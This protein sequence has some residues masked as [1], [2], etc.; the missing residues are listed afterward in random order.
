MIFI[1][2]V[3][4][5][6]SI[7]VLLTLTTR[8]AYLLR[9]FSMIRIPTLF[10]KILEMTYR[11]IYVLL[12]SASDMFQSRLSRTVGRTSTREQQQF[13][14]NTMG[15]LWTIAFALSD[16]VHAAMLVPGLYRYAA[17]PDQCQD[18]GLGLGM[19]SLHHIDLDNSNWW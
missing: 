5:C 19:D 15:A 1:L 6:V 14:G 11:Y 4:A 2:R 17:H 10:I 3:A 16:E 7:A 13:V 18:P 12:H 9:G 8:W